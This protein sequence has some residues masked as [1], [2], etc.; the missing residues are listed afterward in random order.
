[1]NTQLEI[2]YQELEKI[3]KED[4]LPKINSKIKVRKYL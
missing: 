3:S 4:D 1:M 2:I